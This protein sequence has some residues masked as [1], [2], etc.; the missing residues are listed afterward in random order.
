MKEQGTPVVLQVL[1][2]ESMK[3]SLANSMPLSNL[4]QGGST[5]LALT[6]IVKPH[7]DH[8]HS[9]VLLLTP[10]APHNVNKAN[11]KEVQ[12]VGVT[13]DSTNPHAYEQSFNFASR[14]EVG[15]V[16]PWSNDF[17]FGSGDF[18]IEAWLR[19]EPG[20]P[21]GAENIGN[22][23]PNPMFMFTGWFSN[24]PIDLYCRAMWSHPPRRQY[25]DYSLD[26]PLDDGLFHH[27]A[28][29]RHSDHLLYFLDG[30]LK[31]ER[32]HYSGV[33]NSQ[34]NLFVGSTTNT[35]LHGPAH[36]SEFRITKGI[37]RYQ[38]D[39]EPPSAFPKA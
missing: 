25:M 38:D 16:V 35:E 28:F 12:N 34:R 3:D 30:R 13:L 4:L 18:T 23:G 27:F 32:V 6:V 8:F 9:V 2:H 22:G 24:T 20:L 26:E 7:D 17:D 31:T 14:K 39:F 15:F 37:A 19:I 29:V 21:T 5:D 36:I 1:F 33:F 10:E 11:G